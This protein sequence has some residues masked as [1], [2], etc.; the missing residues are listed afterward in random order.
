[1]NL[2]QSLLDACERTPE[3][4]AFPGIRYDELLARVARIAGGSA[5]SS[6]G[7]HAGGSNT[8]S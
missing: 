2:A 1:M 3:A 6:A 8:T 5:G 7:R 4:E